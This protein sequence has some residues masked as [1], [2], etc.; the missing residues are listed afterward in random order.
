MSAN[1]INGVQFSSLFNV[2]DILCQTVLT[3][4]D[5]ILLKLLRLLAYNHGIGNVDSAYQSV[6]ERERESPTIIAPGIAVPHAR[7][8]ALKNIRV[9]VAT[10]KEGI[11]YTPESEEK[12]KLII[13]ILAPKATPGAYLQALSALAKIC[14]DTDTADLVAELPTDKEVWMFFDRGGVILPEYLCARDIMDE[15]DVKLSDN[16]TLEDAI[17]LFVS[18]GLGDLPVID[19]DG[20]LVGVVTANELLRICLPDYILWMEDLT[21]IINF[22][23]FA[24]ILRKESKTWLA[25]IMTDEYATVAEDAPAIQVAKEITKRHMDRAYVIR[26]EKLVGVVSLHGFLSKILRE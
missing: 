26:D 21:P 2:S 25:D 16:D 13:L 1:G 19:K 23:P 4:R 10:S 15:V 5:E 17:D 9:A 18:Q 11:I 14:Y 20:D 12:I 3:S 6:L 7:L 24:E 22:E 8:D